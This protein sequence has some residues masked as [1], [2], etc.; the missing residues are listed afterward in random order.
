[1]P[2][3]IEKDA[4]TGRDTT[5]HVWDGIKELNTPLPSWW[6]WLFYAT[7]LF[8]VVWVILYPAI[9]TGRSSTPGVLNYSQRDDVAKRL[10]EGRERQAGYLARI[11]AM[12]VD[13]IRKEPALAAFAATGGRAAFNNNCAQCHQGGGA[14]AKGYPNLADD[15]WLWGGTAEAIQATIVHGIRNADPDSRQSMMPK[16]GTDDLLKPQEIDAVAEFVLSLSGGSTVNVDALKKGAIIYAD[17]CVACHGEKGEGSREVGAPS[18]RD[19]IWLYGGDKVSIVESIARSRSGSMPA[20]GERLDQ[21][22]IKMLTLYVHGLG[23]GQ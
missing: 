3:K 23:G 4:V 5:G 1:M 8:S 7:I 19:R 14:G 9:P 10:A 13:D 16:F 21:A 22:T 6:L 20:W 12:S 18:L 15:D 2:T 17:Q 11:A